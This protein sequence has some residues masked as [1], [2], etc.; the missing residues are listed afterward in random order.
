MYT[1]LYEYIFTFFD[2]CTFEHYS[3]MQ[4]RSTVLHNQAKQDAYSLEL[5]GEELGYMIEMKKV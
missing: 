2:I 3:G 1:S 4:M 5:N